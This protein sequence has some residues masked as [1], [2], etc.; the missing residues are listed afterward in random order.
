MGPL[1]WRLCVINGA[2]FTVGTLALALS[3]A[4]VSSPVL[5]R[6]ILVLAA[7]LAIILVTN[8]L[9]LRTSLAPLTT[10]TALMHRVD[11]HTHDRAID[12]GNG[13]LT[14]L[15]DSFNT[16]LER[17]ENERTSASAHALAAQEGE[18][19][20]IARELHDEIGQSLTVALLGLKRAVDRAPEPLK[21][22]LDLVRDTIRGSLDEV[23]Q[24][25]RRLRPGVLEDLGLHSALTALAA[26]VAPAV[27]VTRRIE[28]LPPLSPEVELVIYRIAQESLTNVVRHSQALKV[29]LSLTAD[30]PDLVLRITDDGVGGARTEGAGMRGMQERALL[31]GARLT[32][33]SADGTEVKLTIPGVIA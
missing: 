19:Q 6:E 15:I 5:L 21:E 20:R 28:P 30:G 4:T 18:R 10:L 1:F 33:T 17:L 16:M 23:R 32:V 8:A 26:D 31:I 2:V 12:R 11:L 22:E 25:A 3:P 27:A 13:D 14:H 9:L 29:W 24:V 7:G